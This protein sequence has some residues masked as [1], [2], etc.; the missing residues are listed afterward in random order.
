[1]LL[2]LITCQ[3][4]LLGFETG[5]LLGAPREGLKSNVLLQKRLPSL[6]WLPLPFSQFNI[7]TNRLQM[8][9]K[10]IRVCPL[11][12]DQVW[13]FR[14]TLPL[15]TWSGSAEAPLVLSQRI[16]SLSI[17]FLQILQLDI[18]EEICFCS[19]LILLT[20]GQCLIFKKCCLDE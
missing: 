18:L 7:F 14:L 11:S 8:W 16:L 2:V 9:L 3:A 17:L 1:M 10:I 4:D 6:L 20:R 15:Q 19:L 5:F 12:L 13:S